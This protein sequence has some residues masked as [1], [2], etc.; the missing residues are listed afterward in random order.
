MSTNLTVPS[1][2]FYAFHTRH[3]LGMKI[4]FL[5]F[6]A[7]GLKLLGRGTNKRLSFLRYKNDMLLSKT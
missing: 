4:H 5:G 3:F 1:H 2:P 6:G 7:G